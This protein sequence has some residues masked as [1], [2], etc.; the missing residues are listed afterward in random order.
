MKVGEMARC[1]SNI[2]LR[3]PPILLLADVC[4]TTSRRSRLSSTRTWR[5]WRASC[6]RSTGSSK[7]ATGRAGS[8]AGPNERPGCLNFFFRGTG[9]SWPLV[10]R[11]GTTAREGPPSTCSLLV[12]CEPGS[13]A[14]DI[15]P[16][17]RCA[18][19]G[20]LPGEMKPTRGSLPPTDLPL[21]SPSSPFSSLSSARILFGRP[22]RERLA[23][24]P[25]EPPRHAV[26]P[27]P[28]RRNT[29]PV[30]RTVRHFLLLSHELH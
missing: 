4:L 9:W 12:D 26:R 15:C 10:H 13:S 1:G 22:S 23:F 11:R 20:W 6:R 7:G 21:P 8:P 29:L 2:R 25:L 27:S 5:R 19:G 30:Q 18:N 28:L 14:S 3:L 24:P 16:C 17:L